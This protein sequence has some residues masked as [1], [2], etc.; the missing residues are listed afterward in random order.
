M[1]FTPLALLLVACTSPLP[2]PGASYV[3]QSDALR[4]GSPFVGVKRQAMVSKGTPIEVTGEDDHFYLAVERSALQKRWF[5]SAYLKQYFPGAVSYGAARSLGTR[6]VSFRIQNNKLYVFSADDIKATSDT[7]DPEVIIDAYPIITD[8][9]PFN[10]QAGHTDYVLIDPAAGLNRFNMESDSQA[11]WGA[12]FEIELSYVQRLRPIADGITYE[13]LFTGYA[14]PAAADKDSW[15]LG[16]DNTLR[17][18]GTL[19]MALR[20][21]KESPGFTQTAYDERYFGSDLQLEKNTGE[22]K[23]PAAKWSIHPGMAPII[24]KLSPQFVEAANDP[25]LAGF[26]LVQAVKNGVERWNEAFGFEALRAEI[27]TADDSYADDDTNYLIFDKDPTY[28]AAF[29]NWRTNPNTGEIRGASVYFNGIW[30]EAA[31]SAAKEPTARVPA[32]AASAKVPVLAWQG[33]KE[34]RLCTYLQA[35]RAHHALAGHTGNALPTTEKEKFEEYITHVVLHEVGHTLGLRH[36]FRGSLVPPSSSVMDY[37]TDEDTLPSGHP[38]AYDVDAIKYLYGLASELPKQ[39]FCNDGGVSEASDCNRFDTGATPLDGYIKDY[40]AMVLSLFPGGKRENWPD[41]FKTYYFKQAL[42]ELMKFVREG[43]AALAPVALAAALKP[44]GVSVTSHSS[45]AEN[46]LLNTFDQILVRNLFLDAT[47]EWG[48]IEWSLPTTGVIGA[49][50]I[51]E[52]KGTLQNDD[53]LRSYQTRR[54]AVDTLKA[55][56]ATEAYQALRDGTLQLQVQATALSGA[57]LLEHQDLINR[58]D[59]AMRPY[60]TN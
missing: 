46:A 51:A 19:G 56:Q 57:A 31:A 3:P 11:G 38:G 36:N 14:D 40:D 35:D 10:T 50:L 25:K 21:Y 1:R 17:G 15:K 52:L 12:R 39:P 43:D 22:T 24:W 60:F 18:S 32:P 20:E 8:Y 27:A 23:T 41:F 45:T 30:F 58:A 33:M 53:G 44:I 49:Q 48:Q 54:V 34:D 7:F 2:T 16:E 42:T 29:A 55:M 4:A 26:D 28:G 37:L 47:S 5:L 6:I 9:D 59:A 13:L